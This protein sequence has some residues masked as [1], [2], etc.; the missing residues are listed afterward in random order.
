MNHANPSDR[1]KGGGG[2]GGEK[3]DRY[4]LKTIQT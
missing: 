4:T 1:E 3:A 2:G